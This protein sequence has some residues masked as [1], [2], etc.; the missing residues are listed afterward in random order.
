M[1]KKHDANSASSGFNQFAVCT[2]QERQWKFTPNSD[3]E[4]KKQREVIIS[5]FN[6][7]QEVEWESVRG[8]VYGML[9]LYS[10]M[11]IKKEKEGWLLRQWLRQQHGNSETEA[12][13]LPPWK[14]YRSYLPTQHLVKF[15]G[16]KIRQRVKD[17]IWETGAKRR[18]LPGGEHIC[19]TAEK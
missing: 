10:S 17:A 2:A 3:T 11:V 16:R 15:L 7:C 12:C 5:T 18:D 1:K 4:L 19:S 13:S 8:W 14:C 6:L 9:F